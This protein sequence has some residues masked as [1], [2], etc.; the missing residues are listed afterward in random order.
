[1]KVFLILLLALS[2]TLRSVAQTYSLQGMVSDTLK[3]NVGNAV[4]SLSVRDS[5]VG[6]CMS[7][8]K[9]KY[10]FKEVKRGEY[11][12]T[13]SHPNYRPLTECV[14]L[15]GDKHLRHIL[16]PISQVNLEDVVVTADRSNVISSNALGTTF[17]LSEKARKEKSMYYALMEIPSLF[18]DPIE[19]KLTSASGGKVLVL[20]NGMPKESSLEALDPADVEAV[21]VISNPSVK[22]LKDNVQTV[23][24]LKM[25]RKMNPYKLLNLFAMHDVDLP[26]GFVNGA[27]ETGNDKYS[28]YVEGNWNYMQEKQTETL[29]QKSGETF[30]IQQ[31]RSDNDL[32][33]YKVG[34]GGDFLPNEKNFLNYSFY[35]FG[36]TEKQRITGNGE[37]RS[38]GTSLPIAK[39]GS[40]DNSPDSYIAKIYHKLQIG[41]GTSLENSLYYSYASNVSEA[42][43]RETGENY[44]Y[45]RSV[46]NK[47]Q[48][49]VGRYT[50]DFTRTF[51]N[52]S[53]WQIG[54]DLSVTTNDI[55]NPLHPKF[56]YRSWNEYLYTSYNGNLKR[57]SY[58][59]S[60]GADIFWN[61]IADVKDRYLRMKYTGSLF[62]Q[63]NRSHSL[64]FFAMGYTDMP[65]L[66]ALNPN[67]TS[68]DSLLVVR[69]NPTLKPS[70]THYLGLRYRYGSGNWYVEPCLHYML[71]KDIP[72]TIGITENGIYTTTYENKDKQWNIVPSINVRYN[73]P[74][75]GNVS[76]Y[77]YYQRTFWETRNKGW[78]SAM[79]RWQ[80]YYKQF[81]WYGWVSFMPYNY[82]E[83]WKMK[84]Y[85]NTH[86]ELNWNINQNWCIIA[87][88]NYF[89]QKMAYD[90]WTVDDAQHYYSHSKIQYPDRYFQFSVG[91]RFTWKKNVQKRK[92]RRAQVEGINLLKE[93][94]EL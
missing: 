61:K 45:Q 70:Y 39:T 42:E 1:M 18:V 48:Q 74:K 11:M 43:S 89:I 49:H 67:N 85:T 78:F 25:K 94:E 63:F 57:L 24:N 68:T 9:G 66:A 36:N 75:W 29:T 88:L 65:A 93:K 34:L 22:Y 73:I 30:R 81:G 32:Y 40:S 58:A 55:D 77:A 91:V 17:H 2:C 28:F 37:F 84:R 92:T 7:D 76:L 19:R 80:L 20:I 83:Y 62:Y 35:A 90:T 72:N 3:Q 16:C 6:S 26:R 47:A 38:D 60:V 13:V 21:E 71:Q 23:V 27:F 87:S 12:L 59:A 31:T 41:N 50:T 44:N 4:I 46:Y 54:S 64:N 79:L 82:G 69:G 51:K 14:D 5:L 33:N 52:R 53:F 8:A 15:N 10:E 56:S 86:T